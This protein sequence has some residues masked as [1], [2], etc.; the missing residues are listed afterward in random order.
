[1]IFPR[2]KIN[3]L[4]KEVTRLTVLALTCKS[5][6]FHVMQVFGS[7]PLY[8]LTEVEPEIIPRKRLSFRHSLSQVVSYF[9]NYYTIILQRLY[10]FK[11]GS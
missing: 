11:H 10:H 7:K 1:M 4:K 9:I 6:T 3:H 2:L 5:L 8:D